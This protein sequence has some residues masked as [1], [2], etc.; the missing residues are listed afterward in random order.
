MTRSWSGTLGLPMV[1]FVFM[2]LPACS[3]GAQNTSGDE[4]ALI[5]VVPQGGSEDVNP[6]VHIQLQFDHSMADG[7]EQFCAL[8]LG[9][10]DGAVVSGHWE[11]S[12]DHHLLMFI[13]DQP[14]RTNTRYVLHVGAGMTDEDGHL[15][16]FQQYGFDMGGQWVDQN[17]LGGMMGGHMHMGDEWRDH[18]GTYGMMFAFMTAP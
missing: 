17:M 10:V 12:D 4:V 9:D 13:P 1:A 5:D 16:S 2:A 15:M 3:D 14:L 11:W 18:N 6:N 7:M 8:H